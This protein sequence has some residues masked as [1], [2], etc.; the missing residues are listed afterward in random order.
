M[1]SQ[2]KIAII[3]DDS[4]KAKNAAIKLTKYCATIE[5]KK[6][7]II[8]ALGGDGF[9]LRQLHHV[10]ETGQKLYGLNCG[11]VG[12]LMNEFDIETIN[13]DILIQKISDAV[14]THVHPLLIKAETIEGQQIY[15]NAFNEA[16]LS[17]TSQQA[18][19]MSVAV[20]GVTGVD[21][22][23]GDGV[24]VATPAGSTAYNLAVNGPII[25][26]DSGVLVLGAISPFRP[27]RWNGAILKDS[28]SIYIKAHDIAKR[29][30]HADADF[31]RVENVVAIEVSKITKRWANILF[32]PQETLEQ[33]IFKEQ[34]ARTDNH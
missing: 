21:Q 1:Q 2:L 4:E 28:S 14:E 31:I 13:G 12:F 22:L 9:M 23:I 15:H 26:F 27:R 17:R 19:H 34:F 3:A 8:V 5:P 24:L 11:S 7:D 25:P 6:A 33:R 18:A 16:V 10:F 32:D 20:D 30:V 29:P